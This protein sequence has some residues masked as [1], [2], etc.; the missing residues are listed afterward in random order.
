MQWLRFPDKRLILNGLP[1]FGETAPKLWRL[2]ER[3]K[4]VVRPGV[5]ELATAPSGGRIRFA[6]DTTALKVRVIYEPSEES[7]NLSKIGKMGIALYADG[8]FWRPVWPEVYGE[9]ELVFFEGAPRKMRQFVLYLPLYHGVELREV[10]FAKGAAIRRPA[11]FANPQ[12]VAFYGSSITQ[13]G[14]ASQAGLSYQAILVRMLNIDYVN[15]GFSGEGRGEP[16][17]AAAFA[18]INASCFVL[19]FA[20]NCVSIDELRRNYEPFIETVRAA[21]ARTPIVCITPIFSTKELYNAEAR[22][23]LQAMREVIRE[24]VAS[25]KR[26]G[27]RRVT[28]VEGPE[29]LGAADADGF[30]DG[31]HPNDI[32]FERMAK[33][34]LPVIAKTIGLGR[35]ERTA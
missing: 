33:R 6:S 22:G 31:T 2:P 15:L 5:W 27:D 16:E 7:K 4:G 3:L 30:V 35:G 9:C 23:N 28:L 12:P 24:A 32:G 13:G 18:E 14:C 10:G 34:L 11:A 1:W 19:D 29:L 17:M 26:A 25:R 8:V 21:H 20:Q